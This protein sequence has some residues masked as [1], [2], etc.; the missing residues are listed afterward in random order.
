MGRTRTL[1][2]VGLLCLGVALATCVGGVTLTRIVAPGG[3][4]HHIA[5]LGIGDMAERTYIPRRALSCA[6]PTGDRHHEICRLSVEGRDLVAE[7]THDDHAG[8]FTACRLR[9]GDRLGSCWSGSGPRYALASRVGLGLSEA[10]M[11]SLARQHRF[12]NVREPDWHRAGNA[13]TAIVA[14]CLAGALLLLLPQ[15]RPIRALSAFC[16]GGLVWGIGSFIATIVLL[17]AGLID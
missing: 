11:A 6:N 2:M 16:V 3:D 9:Y 17:S 14:T 12:A 4:Q 8:Q 5:G 15:S 10:T 7:V 13:A 1:H